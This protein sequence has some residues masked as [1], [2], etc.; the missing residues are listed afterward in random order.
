MFKLSSDGGDGCELA[1]DDSGVDNANG[2][3][4]LRAC[5]VPDFLAVVL[6]L[7]AGVGA[8]L[9]PPPPRD[10]G[11]GSMLRQVAKTDTY[12]V[13]AEAYAADE[14][15]ATNY[16]STATAAGAVTT[17]ASAPAAACR[18]QDQRA[19]KQ[20]HRRIIFSGRRPWS[21]WPVAEKTRRERRRR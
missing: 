18:A 20:Q 16:L 11:T 12:S 2:A 1:G 21:S 15:A 4:S 17:P 13:R 19:R 8:A 10:G 5:A 3:V 9:A 7:S 14:D 6:F